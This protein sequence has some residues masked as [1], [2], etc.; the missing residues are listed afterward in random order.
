[1]NVL[2]TSRRQLGVDGEFV[3]PV[4]S[5]N[6]DVS[7]RLLWMGAGWRHRRHMTSGSTDE[8]ALVCRPLDGLPLGIKLAASQ[9]RVVHLG[10]LVT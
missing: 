8:V 10:E 5:L 1:M 3:L 6:A 9:L 2:A 4:G 7:I